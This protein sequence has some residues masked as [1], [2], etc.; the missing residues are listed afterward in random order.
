MKKYVFIILLI[1][2]QI[3]AFSIGPRI[4]GNTACLNEKPSP[5]EI[6]NLEIKINSGLLLNITNSELTLILEENIKQQF[7]GYIANGLEILN[8]IETDNITIEYSTVL[9]TIE[10]SDKTI[11]VSFSTEG[12]V[13]SA[14]IYIYIKLDNTNSINSLNK[15]HCTEF[16]SLLEKADTMIKDIQRQIDI[17]NSS[18][19]N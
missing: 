5:P 18:S 14:K 7:I 10:N 8:T 3:T 4:I 17:V 13:Q 19:G 2:T 1:L 6:D 12:S 9:G 15:E 16:L 11:I